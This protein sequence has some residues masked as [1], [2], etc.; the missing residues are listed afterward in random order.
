MEEL[1]RMRN[2]KEHCNC[3][4]CVCGDINCVGKEALDEMND[5]R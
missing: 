2:K 1:K 5:E 4:D 3:P